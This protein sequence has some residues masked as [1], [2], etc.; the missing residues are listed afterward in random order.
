[1]VLLACLLLVPL[2]TLLHYEALRTLAALLPRLPLPSRARL[3]VAVLGA[4]VSHAAQI[5]LYALALWALVRYGTVGTLGSG[6]TT[7]ADVLYFSAQTYTSL[8]Y[9]DFVPTGPL[10]ALASTETLNGLLLVGW[11]ASFLYLA[12]ERFWAPA[13]GRD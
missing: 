7:F 5:A 10:R 9:G 2:S 6:A 13:N 3:V 8:G 12:M 1:M 4:F 11:S